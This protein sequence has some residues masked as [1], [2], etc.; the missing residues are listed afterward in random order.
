MID[1]DNLKD[2]LHRPGLSRGDQALLCLGVSP[3]GPREVG[4]VRELAV[5]AGLTA[6][7][8]WN[9]SAVLGGLKGLAVRTA[10]GWELNGAGRARVAKLSGASAIP[11]AAPKLRSQLSA[12]ASPSIKEF[13]VEAVECAENG[14]F[15]AAVVLSWVGALAMLYDHVVASRLSA[16]NAEARRRDSRWRDAKTSDDLARMGEYDFLQILEAISILGKSVKIELEACLKLRNGCGHP[17]SL[18]VAEHRVNSHIET[19][20]LNVFTRF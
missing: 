3:L 10:T 19:L 17:N 6:A 14:Q 15:R 8:N 12:I 2:L 11:A 18:K 9:I 7:K 4:A 1:K 20:L 13:V 5:S 16:F